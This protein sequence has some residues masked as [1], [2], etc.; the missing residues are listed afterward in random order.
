MRELILFLLDVTLRVLCAGRAVVNHLE[1]ERLGYRELA[2]LKDNWNSIN[3][4]SVG[5]RTADER[6]PNNFRFVRYQGLAA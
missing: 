2:H 3:N 1:L 4:T 5:T 6:T